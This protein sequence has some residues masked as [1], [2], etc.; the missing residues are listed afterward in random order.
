M[1]KIFKVHIKIVYYCS[2]SLHLFLLIFKSTI[3]LP[4]ISQLSIRR[5]FEK[6]SCLLDRI[7]YWKEMKNPSNRQ[8]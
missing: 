1:V 4:N 7:L 3:A 2:I 8:H 5:K 6:I